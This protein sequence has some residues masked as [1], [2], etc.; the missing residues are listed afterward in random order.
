MLGNIILSGHSHMMKIKLN[1]KLIICVPSLS[2][3]SPDKSR[4]NIPGFLDIIVE[5][6]RKKIGAININYLLLNPD[7][8]KVS[9][10]KIKIKNI[11]CN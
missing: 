2:H 7:I 9:E 3:N 1:G 6:E 4:E 5:Y 11:N 8:Q 10:N